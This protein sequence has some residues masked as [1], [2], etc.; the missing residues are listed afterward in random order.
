MTKNASTAQSTPLRSNTPRGEWQILQPRED[1]HEYSVVDGGDRLYVV[2]NW[3]A[4]NFRVMETAADMREA[5]R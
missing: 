3:Q 2:T 4:V 1:G 5:A